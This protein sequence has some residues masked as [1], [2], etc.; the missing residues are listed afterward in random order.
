M[1]VKIL[2]NK[3]GQGLR[4]GGAKRTEG[5]TSRGSPL[6]TYFGDP[7]GALSERVTC[8]KTRGSLRELMGEVAWGRRTKMYRGEGGQKQFCVG[9]GFSS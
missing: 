7:P 2:T 4:G 5:Q 1:A 9:Q 6:D 3:A 8:G